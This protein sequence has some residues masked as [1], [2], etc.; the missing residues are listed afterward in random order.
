M[1]VNIARLIF[2]LLVVGVLTP[3]SIKMAMRTHRFCRKA[4]EEWPGVIYDWV[5]DLPPPEIAKLVEETPRLEEVSAEWMAWLVELIVLN[6]QS[7]TIG[8]IVVLTIAILVYRRRKGVRRAFLRAR[9]FRFEALRE[10]STF[11]NS[12]VPSC[13]VEL[14][15]AGFLSDQFVGYGL[16]FGDFLVTPTHVIE[17]INHL[18][19]E[20]PK[21][22][23]LVQVPPIPSETVSDVSYLKLTADVWSRLGIAGAR[24]A[25][26]EAGVMATCTGK[27]GQSSGFIRKCRDMMGC[28]TY[29]GSTVAGM[30]GAA[31]VTGTTVIGM[32][33]GASGLENIG[34]AVSVIILELEYLKGV[35]VEC[36]SD[37]REHV[38]TQL[39]EQLDRHISRDLWDY[40]TLSE[41]VKKNWE[42]RSAAT[43]RT[44]KNY[45]AAINR[46]MEPGAWADDLDYECA[47]AAC[48][49]SDSDKLLNA[50]SRCSMD[51][52]QQV[53][54]TLAVYLKA[55]SEKQGKGHSDGLP[56]VTFG[57]DYVRSNLASLNARVKAL[58]SDMEQLKRERE[59]PLL[60]NIAPNPSKPFVCG[61][62]GCMRWFKD[63]SATAAHRVMKH[64]VVGESAY[65][66]DV[67]MAVKTTKQPAFLEKSSGKKSE[68]PL[69]EASMLSEKSGSSCQLPQGNQSK[70]EIYR[71]SI[72]KFLEGLREVTAGLG[73]VLEQN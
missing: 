40:S 15:E 63:S 30:S 41:N 72:E 39:E 8:T 60:K 3:L 37:H 43:E 62:G 24:P 55:R 69:L 73:L 67:K 14:R 7:L 53:N 50:L 56:D 6:W 10:G 4:M 21:G 68:K 33:N 49:I 20:G 29:S 48:V 52:L 2:S 58:E 65:S 27:Q 51:Q 12:K 17:Q 1:A 70:E 9:G 47:K 64:K 46:M 22:K 13:Q 19:L 34:V 59:E 18:V 28:V 11:I 57:E 45:Q 42:G 31:Y 71:K 38:D 36:E 25:R 32:H 26:M 23:E 35:Y 44:K 5:M 61:V 16:R 54:G 66:S